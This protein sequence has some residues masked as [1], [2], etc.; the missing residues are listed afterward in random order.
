MN[1]NDIGST[2]PLPRSDVGLLIRLPCRHE[3]GVPRDASFLALQV[4]AREHLD[5]CR[6]PEPSVPADLYPAPIGEAPR[7]RRFPRSSAP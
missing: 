1:G 7:I 4:T 3:V 5:H 6:G 2:G